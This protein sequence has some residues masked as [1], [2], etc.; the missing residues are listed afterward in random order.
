MTAI[1]KDRRFSGSGSDTD[2]VTSSAR[3]YIS[4]INKLLSWNKRRQILEEDEGSDGEE[5]VGNA[6][7]VESA[8]PTVVEPELQP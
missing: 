2:I 4:A 8:A 3:A 6:V 7:Q 5:G 1:N